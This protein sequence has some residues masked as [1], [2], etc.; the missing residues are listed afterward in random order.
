MT[1]S[2]FIRLR[3]ASLPLERGPQPKADF[4]AVERVAA[5]NLLLNF[6]QASYVLEEW[7]GRE[8]LLAEISR[9]LNSSECSILGLIGFGGEGKSSLARQWIDSLSKEPAFSA[10]DGF[11]WWGFYERNN[12]DEF[13]E[14]ALSYLSQNKLDLNT[15]PSTNARANF[16]A[17]M[18]KSGRYLFVLDGLEVMQY[19]S[20]DD[21][22]FIKNN[23]LFEF[24]TYFATGDHKSFCLITSR[25]PILDLIQFITYK[26]CNVDRLSDLEGRTLLRNIGVEGNDFQ[27]DKIVQDWDGHALTLILIGA[28]L[29]EHFQGNATFIKDIPL[30]ASSEERY[31]KVSR[32]LNR[33]NEYL[34]KE[35]QKGV[36]LLSTFRL[37]I[38]K[39]VLSSFF[40][41]RKKIVGRLIDNRILRF[42]SREKHYTIHPLIRTFYEKQLMKEPSSSIE[43]HQSISNYYLLFANEIPQNPKIEDFTYFVEAVHHLCQAG[44]YDEADKIRIEKIEQNGIYTLTEVLGADETV[45]NLMMDFF[46]SNDVSRDPL[47][48]QPN[49][50]S[51]ILNEIG[52]C[53][54]KLGRLSEVEKFYKRSLSIDLKHQ[55]LTDAVIKYENLAEL[56]IHLGN[57]TAGEE[58]ICKSLE[59]ARSIQDRLG[60]RTTLVWYGRLSCLL[61][62]LDAAEN[63]FR[64]AEELEKRI[65]PGV[66]YLFKL[67]GIYHADF[68]KRLGNT[69][70]AQKVAE[71]NLEICQRNQWLEYMSRSHRVLGDLAIEGGRDGAAQRHYSEALKLSRSISKQD[72]LIE[73]LLAQSRWA[74][75]QGVVDLARSNLTEALLLARTG[76]YRIYEADSYL[77]MA[78]L[79]FIDNNQPLAK[80]D[81]QRA[82]AISTEVGYYLGQVDS[83]EL[84]SRLI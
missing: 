83:C 84:L 71:A 56:Y 65:N 62:R 30:P 2:N 67:R 21:Y 42:N 55:D 79:H 36:E 24:L 28:Y 41:T 20:G 6:E 14:A 31:E 52:L 9:S 54:T 57:L 13:F 73:I 60:E 76:G 72:A 37:P 80:A 22:A 61:G 16:L 17:A 7:V 51:G 77:A 69:D 63:A 64:E 11:F 34:D 43:V 35:E 53:L 32:V 59:L 47:V 33:Y 4:E 15:L 8:E 75:R 81:A 40:E 29:V 45:L 1:N 66:K 3:R 50:K 27:I 44:S 5:Q 26:Q 23:N 18:L 38:P 58:A 82:N 48:S 39:S 12:I 49:S 46:P 19:E 25:F 74:I 10:L 70:Y 68:L 78:W